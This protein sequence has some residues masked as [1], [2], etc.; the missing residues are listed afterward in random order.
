[1]NQE[2]SR[3]VKKRVRSPCIATKKNLK[4]TEQNN[5]KIILAIEI[6]VQF[7]N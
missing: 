4:F 3:N 5:G 1:M 6:V 2:L 7:N